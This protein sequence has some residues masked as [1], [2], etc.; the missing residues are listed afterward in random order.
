MCQLDWSQ[1]LEKIFSVGVYVMYSV[2]SDGIFALSSKGEIQIM[3]FYCVRHYSFS[4]ND[5]FII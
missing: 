1:D 3:V 5:F 2:T 4:F